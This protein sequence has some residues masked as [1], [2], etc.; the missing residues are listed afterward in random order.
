MLLVQFNIS[1]TEKLQ[2]PEKKVRL[3]VAGDPTKL[4]TLWIGDCTLCTSSY[5]N[6]IR[7][8]NLDEDENYALTLYDHQVFNDKIE[9]CSYEPH[10]RLLVGGTS[11][12]KLV[13]WK[14]VNE[15]Y[16]EAEHWKI[17]QSGVNH[18]SKV[19]GMSVGHGLIAV[20]YDDQVLLVQETPI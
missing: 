3:S 13:I 7:C 16:D 1:T 20:K 18:G 8:W 12:G 6:L 9:A 15:Q 5:E 14:N 4:M 17:V 19:L 10:G 2:V 11:E